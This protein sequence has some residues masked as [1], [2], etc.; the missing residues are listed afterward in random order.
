MAHDDQSALVP[1][2]YSI[3]YG[4]LICVRVPRPSELTSP[5][6]HST[7]PIGCVCSWYWAFSAVPSDTWTGKKRTGG[8][9]GCTPTWFW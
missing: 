7:I 3:W 4:L 9:P 8:E 5:S 6:T 1:S 2:G